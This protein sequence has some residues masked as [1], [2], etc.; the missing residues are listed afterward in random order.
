MK[1]VSKAHYLDM[2]LLNSLLSSDALRDLSAPYSGLPLTANIM[3]RLEKDGLY[4]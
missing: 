3:V 1:I 4:K 2:A